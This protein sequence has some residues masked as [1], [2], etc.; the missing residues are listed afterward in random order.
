MGL[1]RV[2]REN[3]RISTATDSYRL[4]AGAEIWDLPALDQSFNFAPE[5][6]IML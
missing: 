5:Q 6:A 3:M 1:M 2:Q 4:I